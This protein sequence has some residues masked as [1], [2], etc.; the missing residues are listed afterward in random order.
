MSTCGD[1]KLTLSDVGQSKLYFNEQVD[2]AGGLKQYS[3][4]YTSW[5]T[6]ETDNV[7]CGI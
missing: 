4:P 3:L 7:A 2:S 5:F 1:E 6:L